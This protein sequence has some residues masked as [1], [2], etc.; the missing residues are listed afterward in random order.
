MPTTQYDFTKYE[1][2]R[3]ELADLAR[4]F[5]EQAKSFP[6][7]HFEFVQVDTALKRRRVVHSDCLASFH[8]R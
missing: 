3:R 8:H 5:F 4:M 7:I 2:H 1:S 6:G